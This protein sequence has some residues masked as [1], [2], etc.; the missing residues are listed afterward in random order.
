M[1]W[2]CLGLA[3]AEPGRAARGGHELTAGRVVEAGRAG[4]AEEDGWRQCRLNPT[5]S[6]GRV[7]VPAKHEPDEQLDELA[8]I[9]S[10]NLRFGQKLMELDGENWGGCRSTIRTR[11]PWIKTTQNATKSQ[12]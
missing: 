8:E 3:G 12:I 10:E 6:A 7:A 4:R 9:G 2:A 5:G 1:E 11:N